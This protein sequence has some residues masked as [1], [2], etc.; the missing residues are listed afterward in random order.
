MGEQRFA[1]QIVTSPGAWGQTVLPYQR[2][3]SPTACLYGLLENRDQPG[4][5]RAAL[6]LSSPGCMDGSCTLFFRS[7]CQNLTKKR[8]GL[9]FYDRPRVYNKHK[10]IRGGQK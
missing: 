8:F 4:R 7:I 2:G 3:A 1:K 5:L 10:I 9:S 6:M